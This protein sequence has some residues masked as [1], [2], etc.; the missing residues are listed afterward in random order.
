MKKGLI[1]FSLIVVLIAL[2]ICVIDRWIN[3]KEN[4]GLCFDEP[5]VGVVYRVTGADKAR[6]LAICAPYKYTSKDTENNRRFMLKVDKSVC[7]PGIAF[8]VQKN[9]LYAIVQ[10]TMIQSTNT[11]SK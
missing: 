8:T 11:S 2:V 1:V 3:Y 6:N 5:Q 4:E 7:V 10:M 9:G